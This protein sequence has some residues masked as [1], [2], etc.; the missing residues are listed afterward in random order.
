MADI[1]LDDQS[2]RLEG[3]ER[4]FLAV[5]LLAVGLELG[6]F[7]GLACQ[8]GIRPDVLA[9]QLG[10][11]E[12][13][14]R[15]WCQTACHFEILDVTPDGGFRLAP[16]MGTLL[17]DTGNP[18]YFGNRAR[19][20]V[21]HIA[22][23]LV[24]HPGFYRS[25][26]TSPYAS[27]S[28]AFSRDARALTRHI[29][30]LAYKFMAI[31][32]VPGLQQRLEAGMRVLDVGC[33]SGQLMVELAQAFPACVFVGVEADGSAVEDASRL[34]EES[35]VKDRVSVALAAAESMA[36]RGEFDLVNLAAVLHEIRPGARRRAVANCRQ[37]LR[38]SGEVLV[39]D[40]AYPE[41]A[42]D[43]RRP[44]YAPGIK[45]QFYELILGHEHLSAAARHRLLVDSGFRDPVTSPLFGGPIEVTHAWRRAG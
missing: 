7:D 34:V 20:M 37:A 3:Y 26:E 14:V 30:P 40:F 44:E 42:E 4:G 39:F 36:Y 23:D 17:T 6:L 22:A 19:F 31:P 25:G 28:E 24:R 41:T 32:S 27:H 38:E 12:P 11:H 8:D 13:Y 10:L 35:R 1:T 9:R 45:D 15:V 29:V 33:G 16:Y 43:F 18:Y 5:Y 2:A 21:S